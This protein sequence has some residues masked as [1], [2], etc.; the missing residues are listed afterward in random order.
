M[1]LDDTAARE[2]ALTKFLTTVTKFL[3]LLYPF[4][5]KKIKQDESRMR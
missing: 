4:L 5:E 1:S 3:D 2:R